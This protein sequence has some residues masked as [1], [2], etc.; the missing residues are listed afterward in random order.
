MISDLYNVSIPHEKLTM[1]LT[2]YWPG[3][4]NKCLGL[5]TVDVLYSLLKGSSK[6][7]LILVTVE[8]VRIEN[9]ILSFRQE[10]I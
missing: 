1:A 4:I 3:F 6:F 9:A 7:H 2:L 5:E 10:S 8:P